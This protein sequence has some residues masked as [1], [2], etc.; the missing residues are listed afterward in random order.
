MMPVTLVRQYICQVD[1]TEHAAEASDP[2]LLLWYRSCPK[3]THASTNSLEESGQ[4]SKILHC[5][6]FKAKEFAVRSD[7]NLRQHGLNVLHGL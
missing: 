4:I 7:V 3:P 2:G 5:T 6:C 1:A